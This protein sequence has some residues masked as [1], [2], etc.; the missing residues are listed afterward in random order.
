MSPISI[1][2]L[3][4]GAPGGTGHGLPLGTRAD[5]IVITTY[6]LDEDDIAAI[7]ASGACSDEGMDI[8][9]IDCGATSVEVAG[10]L[11]TQWGDIK[12][13]Q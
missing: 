8:L 6:A 4:G 5:E 1:G 11:A 7:M 13:L 3:Y 9:G 12:R 2:A 10:K